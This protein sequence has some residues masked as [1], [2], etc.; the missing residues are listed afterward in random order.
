V[1]ICVWAAAIWAM[2]RLGR[3]TEVERFLARSGS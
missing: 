2:A 1:V 3:T